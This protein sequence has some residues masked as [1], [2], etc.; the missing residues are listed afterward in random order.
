MGDPFSSCI[1]ADSDGCVIIQT[2]EDLATSSTLDRILS[3]LS[4]YPST[5]ERT[6]LVWNVNVFGSDQA[7]LARLLVGAGLYVG[8]CMIQVA[9]RQLLTS[10]E[11]SETV[12]AGVVTAGK[13]LKVG[14]STGG[15]FSLEAAASTVNGGYTLK[16][17]PALPATNGH[18]LLTDETGAMRFEKIPSAT[19]TSAYEGTRALADCKI[20]CSSATTLNGAVTVYPTSD[21]TTAGKALFSTAIYHATAMVIRDVTLPLQVC[22]ASVRSISVDRKS[23]TFNCVCGSAVV[24]GGN[25]VTSAPN[26]VQVQCMIFGI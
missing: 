22:W 6:E 16:L 14:S 9:Q 8:D 13:T 7:S 5:A 18:A 19:V 21:G 24:L 2:T 26:G 20:W 4:M 25:A 15:A 17:P 23:V 12:S 1:V 3:I 11:A 10:V